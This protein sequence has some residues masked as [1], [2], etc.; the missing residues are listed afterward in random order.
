MIDIR[1]RGGTSRGLWQLN[2]TTK[3]RRIRNELPLLLTEEL[4]VL[5]LGRVGRGSSVLDHARIIKKRES[6]RTSVRLIPHSSLTFSFQG[7]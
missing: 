7:E 5:T 3:K 4:N 6:V 1:E 2:E